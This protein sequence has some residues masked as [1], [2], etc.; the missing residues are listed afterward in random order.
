MLYALL[1]F[2]FILKNY[3]MYASKINLTNDLS[4]NMARN[5]LY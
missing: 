3:V 2:I 1:I 5:F 4:K